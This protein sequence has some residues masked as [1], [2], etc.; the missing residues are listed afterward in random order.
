MIAWTDIESTG[1]DE[2]K[3][4]LLE[5]ALVITDDDLN[6]VSAASVV[7][8]PVGVLDVEALDLDPEVRKMHT[9]NGLFAEVKTTPL[10]RYEGELQLIEVVKAAFAKVPPVAIDRCAQCG[11][12]KD[13]HRL[14]GTGGSIC[15]AEGYYGA[16]FIAKLVPALSQTPLAGSTVSFDRRFLKKH[17]KQ[18]EAMFS[19]SS[20]DVSSLVELAKRWAPVIYEARPKAHRGLA[21]V[22]ESIRYLRFFREVGFI[23][24]LAMVNPLL[25]RP[26]IGSVPSLLAPGVERTAADLI[27]GTSK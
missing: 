5:V 16:A 25:V 6:E 9:L 12:D 20:I 24:G 11:R 14:I 13:E 7:V 2:D 1:L 15:Q 27:G 21:D 22:R 23:N 26:N 18:L 3:D 10:H 4:H 19:Y 17:M 8:Q